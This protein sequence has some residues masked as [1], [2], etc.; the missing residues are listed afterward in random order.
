MLTILKS[1]ASGRYHWFLSRPRFGRRAY[2]RYW[3]LGQCR[4]WDLWRVWP[5]YQWADSCHVWSQ[6]L[7]PHAAFTLDGAHEVSK[8]AHRQYRQYGGLVATAKSSL[9]RRP[10]LQPLAQC[11]SVGTCVFGVHVTTV[12]QALFD[13]FR[14][15]PDGS[16][17]RPWTAI[18]EPD[19]V[20]EDCKN[21]EKANVWAQSCLGFWTWPQALYSFPHL[22]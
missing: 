12:N 13:H 3:C 18:F 7:C 8:Q 14:F 6:Y 5:D 21:F 22:G 2:Q 1:N 4:L 20:Q 17:T 11:P 16:I 9:I 19:F 10:S 15:H